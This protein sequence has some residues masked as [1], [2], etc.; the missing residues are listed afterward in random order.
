MTVMRL[1][2]PAGVTLLKHAVYGTSGVRYQQ[3]QQE[4]KAKDLH[5]PL[6]FHLYLGSKL[7]GLYCLDERLLDLE[8]GPT[9][10]FYG[11]YLVV[12][13]TYFSRG[14]GRLLKH[15]AI[16]Y[17]KQRTTCPFLFYA[18]IEEKNLR[19][20]VISQGE[21]FYSIARLKTFIFRR[22]SPLLDER[23]AVASANDLSTVLPML[24]QLYRNHTFK[25]F[26]HIGYNDNYFILKERGQIVAGVQAN[27]VCWRFTHMPGLSGWV[28]M[29]LIPLLSATRRFFNPSRYT[30][31]VLEG[32]YF[33]PGQQKL[34]PVLLESVLAYFGLHSAMLQIDEKDPILPLF[35]SNRMGPISGFQHGVKT[36][37]MVKVVGLESDSSLSQRPQYVSSFDFS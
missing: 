34:L 24:D 37:V 30:F 19:S 28:T 18:F 9:V 35:E 22:Y 21:G 29:N 11:R 33:Q 6:F 2:D 1:I 32:M 15:E 14:Y 27:P 7:I 20:Q 17:V 23:F 3:T 4:I 26:V 10:S 13:A 8:T 16:G 36:H 25:T 12:D 5:N 31:V